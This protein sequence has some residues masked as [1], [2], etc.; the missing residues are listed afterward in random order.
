MTHLSG[1][2]LGA[3]ALPTSE[4]VARVPPLAVAGYA[5]GRLI[6]GVIVL[7]S[8]PIWIRNF[9]ASAYG[10]FSVVQASML[11]CAALGTGWLRQAAL[12]FT[13]RRGFGLLDQPRR[14]LIAAVVSVGLMTCIA[15]EWALG[16]SAL[17]LRSMGATA[18]F[19]MTY[20]VYVLT[21]TAVQRDGG[22]FK[23]NLA[24]VLRAGVMLLASMLLARKTSHGLDAIVMGGVLGNLAGIASTV[25]FP[26]RRGPE[27]GVPRWQVARS[28][29][30]FGWPLGVWL[31][32]SSFTLYAD[33]FILSLFL[34]QSELGRYTAT[35]DLISRGF[36][37]VALPIVMAVH[38]VLMHEHNAGRTASYSRTLR[39]WSRGLLG[40]IAVVV[41]G[42]AV[43]GPELIE[44]L[45]G[46]R[47]IA[48]P[49]MVILALGSGLWQYTAL[50]HK[51]LEIAHRTRTMMGF[52][53]AALAS[54][55]AFSLAVARPLG[56]VGVV[57]GLLFGAL[58]Y[59]TLVLCLTRR[60]RPKTAN[61]QGLS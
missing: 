3:R 4:I 51:P 57:S 16:D 50:A 46:Q 40:V 18:L 34:S 1:P 14:V 39:R 5:M 38:P 61:F 11:I 52:A 35:A 37:M 7:A 31:G 21:Q 48:R 20:G 13:G 15:S 12:R 8:V 9:G 53:A 44:S 47:A 32:I 42:V 33:R 22:V 17:P 59:L 28:Y 29:W 45:I 58:L 10:S 30:S 26:G 60:M 25:R 43:V 36:T 2:E 23:F 19:A 24:E 6:P 55:V 49:A 27:S 41:V 54:E 56:V